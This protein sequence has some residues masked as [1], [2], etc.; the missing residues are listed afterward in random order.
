MTCDTELVK[1]LRRAL[2]A[3]LIIA[4]IASCG[5]SSPTTSDAGDG[6]MC[7]TNTPPRTA[8]G[9]VPLD[10]DARKL[11]AASS[12]VCVAATTRSVASIPYT[13][14]IYCLPWAGGTPSVTLDDPSAN[15]TLVGAEDDAVVYLHGGSLRRV[16]FGGGT[17]TPLAQIAEDLGGA[18]TAVTDDRYY[19]NADKAL[20]TVPRGGGAVTP[21]ALTPPVLPGTEIAVVDGRIYYLVDE[22]SVA[23][24]AAPAAG[25]TG[26]RL[27]TTASIDRFAVDKSGVYWSNTNEAILR[28]TA[29]DGSD[30]QVVQEFAGRGVRVDA[31][32]PGFFYLLTPTQVSRCAEPNGVC[33]TVIAGQVVQVVLT[34]ERM[35][36]MQGRTIYSSC[37][38]R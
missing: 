3:P 2:A 29:L 17:P 21:I 12:G 11:V 7:P 9:D 32:D 23:I 22:G 31:F 36:W 15:I 5:G 35:V 38:P 4:A 34:P 26:E 24:F 13:N 16:P 20:V 25:G 10:F 30:T 28:R 37:H 27:V 19:L 6:A 14:R 8:L 33:T 18:G 1:K